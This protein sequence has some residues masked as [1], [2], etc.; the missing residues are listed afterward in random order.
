MNVSKFIE[1]ANS[2]VS[3]NTVYAYGCTGQILTIDL[4]DQK[5]KQYPKWYTT[6]RIANLK[7]KIGYTGYDC[8]GLIKSILR[9][10]NF[11][12]INA[13]T[14]FSK[15]CTKVNKPAAGCL[16]HKSG[17][18]AICIDS[19]HVIE[20]SSGSGKVVISDIA[21]RNFKEFGKF[22]FLQEELQPLPV[23]T[24]PATSNKE[25][26]IADLKKIIEKYEGRNK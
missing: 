2:I 9:S 25:Q 3:S 10:E 18:I 15:Y 24:V 6:K 13:D 1:E 21:G 12:D 7:K 26:I 20:A 4:I 5:T 16:A 23:P 17:H 11:P 22:N 19:E 14:I 8:S